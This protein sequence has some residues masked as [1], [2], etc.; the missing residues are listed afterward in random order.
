[1]SL[2]HILSALR[3]SRLTVLF[4]VLETALACA[5]LC[6]ALAFIADQA[7]PMLR[8]TG[9]APGQ[10]LYVD[11]IRV[12]LRFDQEAGGMAG[13]VNPADLKVL[14]RHIRGLDGVKAVS[15]AM[16]VPYTNLFRS[17]RKLRPLHGT[18]PARVDVYFGN[19]YAETLGLDL[20][21][22]RAFRRS[23]VVHFGVGKNSAAQVAIITRQ[24]A[25]RLFPDGHALGKRLGGVTNGRKSGPRVIGIVEHLPARQ[26]V[27]G[28]G[29][30][31]A[32]LV[33]AIPDGL[34]MVGFLVRTRPGARAAVAT[35][36]PQLVAQ[37][38]HLEPA[39]AQRVRVRPFEALHDAY[40]RSNR[41]MVWLMLGVL[42]AVIAITV[43]GI[44]GLTG[45]WVQRRTASIGIRRALGASRGAVLRYFLMENFLIVGAGVVLGVVAAYAGN[46]WLM[47]HLEMPRIPWVW[48][49][50]GAAVLWLLGQL[51]V[52]APARRG[53]AVSPV[54]ATKSE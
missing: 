33:P 42:L 49:P 23:E 41:S 3:F 17:T 34:P 35:R 38:L 40:F 21:R 22:G 39:N 12:P 16:G 1:M 43:I 28:V 6:N 24:L 30:D 10:V 25:R 19:N 51:A 8:P 37:D 20:V 46:L 9:V 48:L 15:V 4:L 27:G 53:A 2:R 36:L 47:T 32:M 26:P 14:Q 54:R 31:L 44:M 45:F 5:F 50:V 52:V 13:G 29:A 7:A 18:D 11:R